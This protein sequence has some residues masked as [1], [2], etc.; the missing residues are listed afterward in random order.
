MNRYYSIFRIAG[1]AIATMVAIGSMPCL[2]RYGRRDLISDHIIAAGRHN[3]GNTAMT[4]IRWTEIYP[5]LGNAKADD[6]RHQQL[7]NEMVK[8]FLHRLKMKFIRN[9][10]R[11]ILLH[12]GIYSQ[13]YFT[14]AATVIVVSA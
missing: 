12:R 7:D 14:H 5:G 10:S 8:S 13:E 6:C 9:E 4:A 2:D 3:S 11:K 1:V